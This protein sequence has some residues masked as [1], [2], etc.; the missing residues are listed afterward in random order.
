[1]RWFRWPWPRQRPDPQV[2]DAQ[3]EVRVS[4]NNLEVAEQALS[5]AQEL[6]EWA[7]EANQQNRFDLRLRAAYRSTHSPPPR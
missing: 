1:M 5:D 2:E 6:T 7:R 4:A 3:A